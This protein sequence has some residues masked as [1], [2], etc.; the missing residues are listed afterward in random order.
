MRGGKD[1]PLV[2]SAKF[3]KLS[4]NIELALGDAKTDDVPSEHMKKQSIIV[5]KEYTFETDMGEDG[6][7]HKFTWK[8][9]LGKGLHSNYTCEDSTTGEMVA[10]FAKTGGKSL[11]KVGKLCYTLQSS[12][13]ELDLMILLSWLAMRERQVRSEWYSAGIAGGS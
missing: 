1:G 5:H 13:E 10:Y 3:H 12:T 4:G 8:R 6:K 9:T 7:R 2:A 11:R